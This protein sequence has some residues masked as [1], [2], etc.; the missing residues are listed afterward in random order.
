DSGDEFA[1]GTSMPLKEET[2]TDTRSEQ[3]RRLLILAATSMATLA[4]MAP[5]A[6]AAEVRVAWW[7][8][9]ARQI[10]TNEALDILTTSKL[11]DVTYVTESQ[12]R[13]QYVEKFATQVAG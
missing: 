4:L 13:A 8:G 10:A 12:G 6:S 3:N 9:D 2:M 7:G 11:P 1:T 5:V